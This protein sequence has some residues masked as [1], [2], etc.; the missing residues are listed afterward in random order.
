M[1]ILQV[2]AVYENGILRLP[3]ELPLESGQK[4]R[5]TIDSG[6]SAAKRMYGIVK[7]NGDPDELTRFL[8][9]P[10]EGIWETRDV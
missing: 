1:D 6:I 9:D 3:Y 7:W 8:N 5:V 4:V 10:D 2:E